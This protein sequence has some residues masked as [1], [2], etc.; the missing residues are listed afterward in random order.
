MDIDENSNPKWK[1]TQNDEIIDLDVGGTH[2][3]KFSKSLL[4]KVPLSDLAKIF[5][6]HQNLPPMEIYRQK[7]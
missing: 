6:D 3:I 5:K 2:S 4:D 1:P 7:T